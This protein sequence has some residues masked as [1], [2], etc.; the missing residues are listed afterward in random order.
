MSCPSAHRLLCLSTWSPASGA[1]LESC[2][3]SQRW[4]LTGKVDECFREREQAM[5]PYHLASL[6][7]CALH[8]ADRQIDQVLYASAA[9]ALRL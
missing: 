2:G 7:I 9:T 8:S 6:P 1:D 4:T 3:T 5:R